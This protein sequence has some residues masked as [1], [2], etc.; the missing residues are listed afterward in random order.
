MFKLNEQEY[1]KIKSIVSSQNE[2]SIWS[3]IKGI[4]KGDVY[5]NDLSHPTSAFIKTSECNY[6]TGNSRDVE[7]NSQVSSMIDFWDQLTPDSQEWFEVIP[8]I[9][10]NSYIT[11]YK[12]RHYT[13]NTSDFIEYHHHLKDGF[14]LEKVDLKSIR[15]KNYENSEKV[16]EWIENWGSDEQFEQYGVGYYI[17]NNHTIVS[18]SLSDCSYGDKIAIGIHTDPRYRK[19]GFGLS[20]V[21]ATIKESFAMGYES[22]D[23]LCVDSN[24]GSIAIA[25]KLGFTHQNDYYSFTSYP[26]IENVTDLTEIEWSKWGHYL[27]EASKIHN[28]LYLDCLFSYIKGNQVEDTIKLIDKMRDK[29]IKVDYSQILNWINKLQTYELCS[30]FKQKDWC[31]YIQQH[32]EQV[33]R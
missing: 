22:I 20:V 11:K 24:K 33:N 28:D 7:F 29:N 31:N 15:E 21:S 2:L 14:I 26:P 16:L 12:R 8:T 18:W 10:P 30:N 27:E 23:W 17:H 4:M 1:Q 5:V 25:E 13:L 19:N 32:I 9:H 6:L 3:V